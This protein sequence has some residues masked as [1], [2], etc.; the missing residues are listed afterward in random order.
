MFFVFF[1]ALIELAFKFVGLLGFEDHELSTFAIQ[2]YQHGSCYDQDYEK[3]G[4][5]YDCSLVFLLEIE[6]C[7]YICILYLCDILS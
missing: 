5:D 2:V 4:E 7:Y 6:V 3:D 1:L